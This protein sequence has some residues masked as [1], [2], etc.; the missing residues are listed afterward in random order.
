MIKL[1]FLNQ[2]KEIYGGVLQ[3]LTQHKLERKHRRLQL[4]KLEQG[5]CNPC[6][7]VNLNR[8]E[9]ARLE[10]TLVWQKIFSMDINFPR[11]SIFRRKHN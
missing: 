9:I 11:K 7:N 3:I 8:K 1:I 2:F 10:L 5:S 4:W 6:R